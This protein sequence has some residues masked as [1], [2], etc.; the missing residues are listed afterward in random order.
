MNRLLKRWALQF[1]GAAFIGA[2]LFVG[3]ESAGLLVSAHDAA[4]RLFEQEYA[5]ASDGAHIVSDMMP[6]DEMN[7]EGP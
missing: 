2:G 3:A 6:A 7:G 5:M 1:V 4:M